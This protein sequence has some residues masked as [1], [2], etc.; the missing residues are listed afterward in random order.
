[1]P[2]F[3]PIHSPEEEECAVKKSELAKLEEKL[4]DTELELATMHAE[5]QAFEGEYLRIVGPCLA[6]MEE[7]KVQAAEAKARRERSGE[8]ASCSSTR[9]TFCP[10]QELKSLFREVAKNIHPDLAG[11]EEERRRRDEVMAGANAAYASGNEEE[12]RGMLIRWKTDPRAV[13][14]DDVVAQLIRTIRLIACVK[15]RIRE[16]KKE[17]TELRKSDLYFLRQR[18]ER[19]RAEGRDMLIEMRAGF[20]RQIREQRD[21]VASM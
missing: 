4:A 11:S 14:G 9:Q 12:L 2:D 18:S 17:M 21:R 13:Q 3:Q 19:A 15:N 6:E 5:L 1:V 7:V 8:D 10:S 20:E 16:V